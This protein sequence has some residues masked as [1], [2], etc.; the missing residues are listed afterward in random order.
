[1]KK[2]SI[3]VD[4]DTSL[5]VRTMQSLRRKHQNGEKHDFIITTDDNYNTVISMNEYTFEYEQYDFDE[6]DNLIED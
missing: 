5:S 1:M 3:L 4:A 2:Y 6:Y